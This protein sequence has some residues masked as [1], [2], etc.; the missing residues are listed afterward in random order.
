MGH[1]DCPPPW[2]PWYQLL[3]SL[4]PPSGEGDGGGP[5]RETQMGSLGRIWGSPRAAP[6]TSLAQPPVLEEAL[7]GPADPIALGRRQ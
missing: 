2:G 3:L 7:K 4:S 1:L 6:T 5:G